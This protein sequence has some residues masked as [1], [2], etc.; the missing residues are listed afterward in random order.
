MKQNIDQHHKAKSSRPLQKGEE[1]WLPDTSASG[2]V[3]A[4]VA[5]R[6]YLVVTENRD[7]RWNRKHLVPMD[8]T[9]KKAESTEIELPQV[10][11]ELP[12]IQPELKLE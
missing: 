10:Q 9:T 7:L 2:T 3:Q 11:H 1:V 6:S 8:L 4:E 5:P 12:E